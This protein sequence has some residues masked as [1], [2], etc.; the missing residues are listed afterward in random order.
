MRREFYLLSQVVKLLPTVVD[1]RMDNKDLLPVNSRNL[2]LLH[3]HSNVSDLVIHRLL[4]ALQPTHGAQCARSRQRSHCA[5]CL[6]KETLSCR[7][8]ALGWELLFDALPQ[9]S[10][11]PH[12]TVEPW[13]IA[14]PWRAP[15]EQAVLPALLV[16]IEAHVDIPALPVPH[17]AGIGHLSICDVNRGRLEPGVYPRRGVDLEVPE[18]LGGEEGDAEDEPTTLVLEEDVDVRVGRVRLLVCWRGW[19]VVAVGVVDQGNLLVCHAICGVWRNRLGRWGVRSS[20]RYADAT[21]EA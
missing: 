4:V 5:E 14:M 10:P 2:Q 16:H 18:R 6:A 11:P 20:R 17:P 1:E 21:V 9:P 13:V 3:Q 19:R 12:E 15:E 8:F 7:R